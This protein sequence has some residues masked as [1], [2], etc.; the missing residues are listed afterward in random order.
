MIAV[1]GVVA[2]VVQVVANEVE[3]IVQIARRQGREQ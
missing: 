2:V 3:H 1:A